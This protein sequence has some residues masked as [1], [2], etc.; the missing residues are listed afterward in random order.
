MKLLINRK[1]RFWLPKEIEVVEIISKSKPKY[2]ET[3]KDQPEAKGG[4][5]VEAED[6]TW[7]DPDSDAGVIVTE[8]EIISIKMAEAKREQKLRNMRG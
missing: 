7:Y 2:V 5:V 6:D 4:S 3:R 8:P 1:W